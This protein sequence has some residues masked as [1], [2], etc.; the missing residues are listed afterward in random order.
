MR[1]A[2]GKGNPMLVKQIMQTNLQ[3]VRPDDPVSKV[4]KLIVLHRIAGIPVVDEKD[5]IVG[6]ISEQDILKAMFPSYSEFIQDPML[7]TD[8][9]SMEDRYLDVSKMRV[10]ELMKSQ[11]FTVTPETAVLK[12]ASMMIL[13]RIRRIPVIDG[14]RLVG[15][16]SQGDV[17]KSFFQRMIME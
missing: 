4:A 3:T 6:I 9:K 11:V 15:I 12:A 2:V 13:K 1:D 16:V 7:H 10:R 14:D 5:R 8:F 17:H